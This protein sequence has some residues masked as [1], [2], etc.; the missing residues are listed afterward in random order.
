MRPSHVAELTMSGFFDTVV[1][2]GETLGI[3]WFG[4]KK[5]GTPG[6]FVWS[7]GSPN[8]VSQAN[9]RSVTHNVGVLGC[10][11]GFR[12]N[13]SLVKWMEMKCGG[14]EVFN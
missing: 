1:N 13:I 9:S 5:S 12:Y 2:I 8:L 3:W 14:C 10:L 6:P 4:L 11:T 7:D